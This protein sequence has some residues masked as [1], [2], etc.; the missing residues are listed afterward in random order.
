MSVVG[1]YINCLTTVE[2]VT[3]QFNTSWMRYDCTSSQ[4]KKKL[5]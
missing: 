1:L 2:K 5:S 3:Q 4:V